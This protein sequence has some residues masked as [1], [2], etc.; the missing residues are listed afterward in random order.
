[1]KYLN[2][3]LLGLSGRPHP[4]LL[5]ICNRM[6][7]QKLRFH[8][9]FLTCDVYFTGQNNLSRCDLCGADVTCTSKHLLL[10]CKSLLDIKSRM[11][12]ELLNIVKDVQPSCKLLALPPHNT[13]LTQFL[14]DCTS[15]NLPEDYRIPSH[16]PSVCEIFRISR[17]W[18]F[19]VGRERIRA[20]AAQ[21]DK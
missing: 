8:L 21:T 11:Y 1:M 2:T 13:I 14:L 4:I 7:V 9:K 20:L 12:P 17:D 18:C 3:E 15:I 16:N 10:D 6:D 5:N 19:A